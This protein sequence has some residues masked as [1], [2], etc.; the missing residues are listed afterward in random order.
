VITLL[1]KASGKRSVLH[2]LT[3]LHTCP[4][5]V[6]KKDNK[7]THGTAFH[8]DTVVIA[9][10]IIINSILG[11]PWLVAATVRSINHVQA[12]STK[13]TDKFGND[14]I[15]SVQ[16]TRLTGLFIHVLVLIAIFAMPAVK[17]IPMPALYGVFLYMGLVSLWSNQFWNRITMLLMQPSLF[18]SYLYTQRNKETGEQSVKTSSIHKF[19]LIQLVLFILLYVVKS[20]PTVA[21]AFPIIIAICVPIRMYILPKFFTKHEL[22]LLDAA[23]E[24]EPDKTE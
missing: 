5:Q 13:G 3:R 23:S 8:W 24:T 7:L 12:L 14:M 20:L 10:C 6:N 11:L 2:F 21:I 9:V 22:S 1:C 4:H 17:S 16:Q 18:P 15:V 19:T